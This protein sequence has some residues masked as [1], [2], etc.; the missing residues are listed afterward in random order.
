MYFEELEVGMS[1][2]LPVGVI[3]KEDMQNKVEQILIG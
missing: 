1:K 2:T 3:D